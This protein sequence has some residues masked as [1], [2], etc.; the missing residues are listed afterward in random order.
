MGYFR[1]EFTQMILILL[2]RYD[3]IRFAKGLAIFTI[4]LYHALQRLP[5]D[6]LAARAIILGGTGVHLFFLLSGF[7]LALSKSSTST[8]AFYQRRL[9]K[10]WVPYVLA[11][12]ISL[13]LAF[14]PGLFEQ[15][16]R[17]WL[18]GISGYQMFSEHDIQGFGGHF[19][20][21]STILQFY[22]VFPW[23]KKGL[24]R[25]S[26][27]LRFAGTA[28]L[29]SLL[30]WCT[31]YLLDKG[32]LRIWNSFF[33]QFLWEFA[34]GMALAKVM[35][36]DPLPR[37]FQLLKKQWTPEHWWKWAAGGIL[38]VLM[39]ALLVLKGGKIGPIFNDVPAL[40][41]YGMLTV[42]VWLAGMRF[43]PKLND[44]FIQTGD[45]SY[46]LYLTH[47]IVLEILLYLLR[48]NGLSFNL[49]WVP[50]FVTAALLFAKIF[51]P[52]SRRFS[53]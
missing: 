48:Q 23:L 24:E 46:S 39:M 30:W 1:P 2:M 3:Y 42:S 47:V 26:S 38:G 27:P 37:W 25:M 53:G 29:I 41:G 22:L 7:G 45:F 50:V 17:E 44:F 15:G 6:G 33:L 51:E 40:A 49:F 43:F 11:L 32:H 5:L 34:L 12:S 14:Y 21:I 35:Q 4:I 52:F 16:R 13:L 28:L 20:F 31:V 19:W 36:N 8:M 10:I 9:T 18:A